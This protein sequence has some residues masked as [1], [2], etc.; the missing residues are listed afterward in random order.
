MLPTN[1]IVL[2]NNPLKRFWNEIR[3]FLIIKDYKQQ[4]LPACRPLITF[5]SVFATFLITSI[6]LLTIGIGF[7]CISYYG[8]QIFRIDYTD[9]I[10]LS[11]SRSCSQIL[12]DWRNRFDGRWPP[13]ECICWY[14][15]NLPESLH[16]NVYVYYAL[17][18]YYQNHLHYTRSKDFSQFHGYPSLHSDCEPFRYKLVR[19]I[20]NNKNGTYGNWEYRG[21]VPC[22]TR[23]NSLFND[24]YTLWFM[25]HGNRTIRTV[26]LSRTNI[27]WPVDRAITNAIDYDVFR[28]FTNPPYWG[29]KTI[30]DLDPMNPDNNGL[31]NEALIVW[32]RVAA[33]PDFRKLYARIIHRPRSTFA[34][35]LPSGPYY[36]KID[37]NYPVKEFRG[38]KIFMLANT[39]KYIGGPYAFLSI[40]YLVVG[41]VCFVWTCILFAFQRRFGKSDRELSRIDVRT[42]YL[43]D[44][45]YESQRKYQRQKIK[46]QHQYKRQQ[47][48]F[49]LN[50]RF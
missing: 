8:D 41:C 28:N 34:R 2:K 31:Q 32:M 15:F 22:G 39:N 4:Q 25:D 43:Y 49:E 35:S 6:S 16:S 37:Y 20:N 3:E 18:N 42:P 7:M 13:P 23:A 14:K 27:A 40:I 9:C 17:K 30:L 11:G 26:P 29:N 5:H 48:N 38:R 44:S 33:F 46:R 50:Y 12:T 21:I 45:E 24:T 47:P 10:P 1:E 19:S 36:L